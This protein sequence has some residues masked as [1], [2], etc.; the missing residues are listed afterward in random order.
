M[1]LVDA[2]P[3]FGLRVEAGPVVLRPITDDVLPALIEVALGG[4]HAPGDDPFY[5]P[6]TDVPADE[7]P[8][9]FARFHW[10]LRS[11]WSRERWALELA[12]EYEGQVV[13]V[14]GVATED[15]LAT[16][17]GETGSWLGL[18]HHGRGIG[19]RMRQ[20]LGAL[21]FDHLGFEQLT[22]GAFADNPASN[23]VSRRVGY[24]PNGVDRLARRGT[25]VANNKYLLTPA[26]FI[27][28]TPVSVTGAD[29]V[30][31]FVGLDA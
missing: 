23:G 9:N 13:G 17:S 18:Q 15:F 1:D 30:R 31:Q 5:R 6:W 11:G 26:T 22:S 2:F 7:L 14:Q 19:T 21:C 29:A 3:P 20:A 16:R 12:V 27:R 28:G 10:S 25:W 24:Q 4:V 8:A